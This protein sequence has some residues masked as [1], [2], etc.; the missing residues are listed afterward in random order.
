MMRTIQIQVICTAFIIFLLANAGCVA[1]PTDTTSGP[2]DLYDPNQFAET[3]KPGEVQH[4]LEE[5]TPFETAATPTLAYNVIQTAT[6]NPE[7]MVCLIDLVKVDMKFTSNK[8]ARKID[9]QNPPLYINYSISKP[10]NVTETRLVTDKTGKESKIKISQYSPYAYLNIVI[11]N[12][13][14][15]E[16]Y[17]QD[18]FGK[19]YGFKL[20]RTIQVNKQG[21]LLIEIGGFNVTPT[22]GIWVKPSGNI[23]TTVVNVSTLDCRSQAEVK[24]M[25]Q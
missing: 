14:T 4:L 8:T 21:N 12:P 13:D 19:D 16:I 5:V 10:F 24:R 23:D 15:G 18:G 2:V 25:F 3:T 17:L 6:I 11:R 22:V 7:D 20:N 9:L 1:P